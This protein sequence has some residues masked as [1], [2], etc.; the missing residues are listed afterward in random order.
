MLNQVS[1]DI[2]MYL[3]NIL[4]I[5]FYTIILVFAIF[6][7]KRNS[8]KYGIYLMISSIIVITSNIFYISIQGA[9]LAYRLQVELGLPMMDVVLIL[10][11]ISLF[12]I[13]VNAAGTIFL[14]V[15]VYLVYKTHQTERI[16]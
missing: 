2:F 12:T 1:Y 14:V 16:K 5:I 4:S 10:F 11:L 15:S 8:Y 9:T 13:I 6:I 7:H 3:P